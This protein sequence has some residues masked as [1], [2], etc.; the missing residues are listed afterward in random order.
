MGDICPC[1]EGLWL[2]GAAKEA[3]LLSRSASS[4]LL[5]IVTIVLIVILGQGRIGSN[6]ELLLQRPR[7]GSLHG[8]EG[9][10]SASNIPLLYSW[11]TLQPDGRAIAL[12]AKGES[13][14]QQTNHGK[15]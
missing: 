13:R 4:S 2:C 10:I 15:H 14:G 5:L 8:T 1:R 11:A 9:A 6:L 12:L 7:L 3:H